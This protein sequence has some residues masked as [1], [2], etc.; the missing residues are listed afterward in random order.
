MQE[1]FNNFL[2][3][4][5]TVNHLPLLCANLTVSGI[6]EKYTGSYLI[7]KENAASSPNKPVF[8]LEGEDMYIYYYPGIAG[9]RIGAKINLSG[10]KEGG[11]FL[12]SKSYF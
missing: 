5:F 6:D 1:T 9:W 8:K 11:Y 3:P 7:S 10:E 2:L 12:A 4:D